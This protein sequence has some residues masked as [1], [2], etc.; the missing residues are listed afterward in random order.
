MIR[1][2]MNILEKKIDILG[3][4]IFLLAAAFSSAE[5]FSV[6]PDDSTGT[7][8]VACVGDS[9]TCGLKIE[10]PQENSYPAQLQKL[11]G[12]RYEVQNFGCSGARVCKATRV[13][14]LNQPECRNAVSFKPHIIIVCLG[15]ND[16][17]VPEWHNNKPNFVRD[18]LELIQHFTNVPKI[19]TPKIWLTTLLPVMPPY[20]PYVEIQQ[21]KTEADAMIRQ[22]ADLLNLPVIDLFSPL[23]SEPQFFP[24]G[25]HPDINGAAIIAQTVAKAITGDYGG[26]K[27]P[28]VFGDHMVLQRHMPIP[29]FGTANVGSTVSVKLGNTTIQTTTDANGRWRI[30]LPAM[31]AGGPYELVCSDRSKT[32]RFTDILVG[33]VWYAA[34]Q[35]NMDWPCQ[36]DADW[37]NEAPSADRFPQIRL[38]N[39]QGY[40]STGPIRWTQEQIDRVTIDAYYSGCWQVGSQEWAA[41]ISAV[42]YYFAREIYQAIGVP[43]G[44]IEAAVGGASME[45]FIPPEALAAESL[46]PLTKQW[47]EASDAPDWHRKRARQNLG[48]W[49]DGPRQT[50]MPH[51]PFE[52]S[53]LFNADIADLIPFAIRGVIWYQGETNATD[54]SNQIAWNPE[55]NRL[56]FK[57]LIQSWRRRWGQGD[58]PFYYVQLPNLNRPW[59]LFR[60][61]QCRMLNELPNLGMAVTID[62]GHPTNVH[63]P[64]KREVARRLSLWAQTHL[65][66]RPM[67]VCSGPLHNGFI[68]KDAHTLKVGFD[69]AT[70]PLC[71][72]DGDTLRGFEV[73]DSAGRW[74][75]ANATI[76]DHQ[77]ILF[78][79]EVSNPVAVRYAW[80]PNPQ[81][82]LYNTAG[83]PASPFW[84]GL[85]VCERPEK[86]LSQ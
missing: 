86:F 37:K 20:E 1:E 56:L 79:P 29:I 62:L 64:A 5:L 46:Y 66:G 48:I 9:I 83:L 53:F 69:P 75:S 32:L 38:L 12:D 15:I 76:E 22:V 54:A 18:Y 84:S 70:G 7:V 2:T 13:P 36:L 6:H 40:P 73:A 55:Q 52:P 19:Q 24:D 33:E 23:I 47:I 4:F 61:M 16:A 21:T 81:A 31:E 68:Q 65:Y 10:N 51:H 14:Y 17:S 74:Y 67:A 80:A 3:I 41:S 25:L 71:S 59:M 11:L 72:R 35:S 45:A 50:P 39:R 78:S 34:G 27:L 49:F 63:P 30:D 26:L 85:M 44:I 77:V 43:V 8:R 42:A 28:W 60:D 57:T 82:T 58:F